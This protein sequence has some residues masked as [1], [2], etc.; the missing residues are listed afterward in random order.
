MNRMCAGSVLAT[1][2]VRRF[3]PGTVSRRLVRKRADT[4]S[5]EGFS[6]PAWILASVGTCQ[7]TTLGTGRG[8]PWS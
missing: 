4:H 8:A 3:G 6:R 1:V 7:A 2:Y 5:G